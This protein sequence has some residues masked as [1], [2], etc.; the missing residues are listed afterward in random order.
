MLLKGLPRLSVLAAL[1]LAHAKVM[2]VEPDGVRP[3]VFG[4]RGS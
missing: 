1:S 4:S 2:P 3:G